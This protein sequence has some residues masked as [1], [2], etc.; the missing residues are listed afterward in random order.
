MNAA[1]RRIVPVAASFVSAS[2]FVGA[3]VSS[4]DQQQHQQQ[5]QQDNSDNDDKR[6]PKLVF[7]G[8]GS[9]TGCPKP[10]CT[11]LFQNNKSASSEIRDEFEAICRVSNRAILG[12]PKHNKDYR[13]NP[14]LLI[15]Y[16]N[17]DTCKNIVIDVGKTFRE[18]ALRWF[19]HHAIQSLDAIL[20][21]HHHM[22]AVAGLDD[23]RGFQQ[24]TG[25]NRDEPPTRIPISVYL[26]QECLDQV[27]SQF[28]WLFPNQQQPQHQESTGKPTVKRD[29][30]A[31]NVQVIEE[32]KPFTVHGLKM[33][34]LPV[35]HGSDL[36]SLGF[37]FSI[38]G[39]NGN[40][41]NIVY[42]SDISQLFESTLEYIQTTLPPTDILICDCLLPEFQHPVHYSLEQAVE[43]AHDIK[44]KRTYLIGMSCDAFLPH[45]EMNAALHKK[46]NGT[47]QFAH[48][49]QVV[50]L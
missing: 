41:I 33:T 17:E 26:S 43:L 42:I 16:Y 45:D 21:T 13:N 40:M 32:F 29:V 38:S 44:A 28:P 37:S 4:C 34:P 46:Y 23:V 39:K 20:L 10:L 27:S 8:T 6:D 24:F 22:D 47:I 48:D 5:Q 7:L 19:P 31:L 11:M 36:I 2:V 25:L 50:Y 14:S 9:S 49:G 1:F 35:W 18:G 30:A 3:A 12:D 15:Q